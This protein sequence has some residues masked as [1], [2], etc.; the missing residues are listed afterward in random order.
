MHDMFSYFLVRG[1]S[2]N[3]SSPRGFGARAAS[4]VG[5]RVLCADLCFDF[6]YEVSCEARETAP[7]ADAVPEGK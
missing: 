2:A 6:A 7:E 4:V 1:G 3:L 5:A